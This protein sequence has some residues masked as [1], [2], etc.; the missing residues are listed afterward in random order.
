MKN[1]ENKIKPPDGTG[2]FEKR[3]HPRFTVDL[4]IEYR[5]RD[6]VDKYVRVINVSESGLSIYLSE[7]MEVGQYLRTKLFF[8]L[9]SE[10]KFIELVTQVVWTDIHPEK[11]WGDYRA[12]VRFVDI[13]PA[14]LS[15]LKNYLGSL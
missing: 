10:L 14:D 12:G 4:P 13:S 7:Q 5:R 8:P 3:R 6:L 2:T 11:D 15:N 1:G 9:G